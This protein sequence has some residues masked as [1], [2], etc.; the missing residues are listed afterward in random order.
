[1][2]GSSGALVVTAL[3]VVLPLALVRN[4]VQA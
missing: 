2:F 1:V 3:T 4:T